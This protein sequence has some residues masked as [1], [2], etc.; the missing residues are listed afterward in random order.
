MSDSQE[1]SLSSALA[2]NDPLGQITNSWVRWAG[3]QLS[4]E[5]F[6]ALLFLRRNGLGK[7]ADEIME[8]KRYQAKQDDFVSFT[9]KVSRAE[10]AKEQMEYASKMRKDGIS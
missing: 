6:E 10:A 5:Q 8:A 2:S 4:A 7:L 1:F 9:E 3:R